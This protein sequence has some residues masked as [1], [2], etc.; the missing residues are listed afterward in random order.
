MELTL[1]FTDH[2]VL[3]I[4]KLQD[5]KEVNTFMFKPYDFMLGGLIPFKFKNLMKEEDF[6]DNV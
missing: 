2:V 5:N 6:C 1:D 4:S 3:H